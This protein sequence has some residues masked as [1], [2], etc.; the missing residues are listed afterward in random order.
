MEMN[1]AENEK[2]KLQIAN[3]KLQLLFLE[4]EKLKLE[5]AVNLELDPGAR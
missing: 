2:I 4:I 1:H 3:L 5:R